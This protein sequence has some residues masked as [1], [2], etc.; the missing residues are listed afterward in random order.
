MGAMI[1]KR[2]NARLSIAPTSD[3]TAL[4]RPW[5]VRLEEISYERQEIM[6]KQARKHHYVP[7]MYL[8]AFENTNGQIWVTDASTCKAFSRASENIAA[9][10]DWNRVDFPG[11]P[12]DALEKELGKFEGLIA[13]GIKRVRDTASFGEHGKDR[14][15]IIN[16]VTLLAVRN[17]RTRD[18][19][20]G[21]YADVLRTMVAMPFNDPKRWDAVVEQMKGQ[22]IW[23]KG[24]PTDFEGH[25]KY[26][27][28]N[29]DKLY[30]HKNMTLELELEALTSTYWFYDSRRWR[31]LKANA[32]TG[33]FV[34]TDHPVCIHK[35][36]ASANY[37]QIYA[38][39]FGMADRDVIFT[40]SSSVCLIGRAEGEEDLVEVG[41]HNVAS[42]N[43]TLIGFALKQIYSMDD[44]FYYTRSPH[45]AIGRGFTLLEDSH[46]K[47]RDG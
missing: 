46:F 41:L 11:V 17:P 8:S 31:I 28:E 4:P 29:L 1:S 45:E 18:F 37:G 38:P 43:A 25:K 7:Q 6:G 2:F 10:R 47:T 40:L 16:L 42:V 26:V 22:N 35:P 33:G 36:A 3:R 9:E 27:C 5:T 19:M 44:Q 32:D 21:F 20:H 24:A 14:E 12:I 23:P 15:D 34:T 30:A 39:G 13:P